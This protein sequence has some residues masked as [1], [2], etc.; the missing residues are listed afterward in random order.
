MGLNRRSF[1]GGALGAAVAGF[2]MRPFRA[3]ASLESAIEATPDQPMP[4]PPATTLDGSQVGMFYF[5]DVVDGEVWA[6]GL[7]DHVVAAWQDLTIANIPS[8][9]V[10]VAGEY[11]RFSFGD[12][13]LHTGYLHVVHSR[14]GKS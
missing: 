5:Q 8:T 11:I 4:M 12:G 1:M 3:K 7:G 6:H 10:D 2:V 13:R 14:R 9:V